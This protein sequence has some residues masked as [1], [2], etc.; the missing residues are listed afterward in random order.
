MQVP[1]QLAQ[2]L[3]GD[4]AGVGAGAV[5][6]LGGG[7]QLE[8]ADGA[9]GVG[10]AQVG[11]A[12]FDERAVPAAGVLFGRGDRAAPS[13][14][15]GGGAGRRQG[16]ERG[17]AVGLGAVGGQP[18]ED[19]GQVQGLGGQA[20]AGFGAAD[21]PVDGVGAVDRLQDV[22]QPFGQGV[23]VGDAEGHSRLLDPLLGPGEPGGQGGRGEGER[24]GDAGDRQAQDGVEHERGAHGGVDRRV[25]AHQHQFQA[26]VADG[27]HVGCGV[28][29]RGVAVRVQRHPGAHGGR[30][31]V[32]AQ[33]VAG[34]RE[35]PGLG[36]GGHAV[37]RPGR[38]GALVG[39][40]EGVLGGGQVSGGR[41]QQGE[42]A[43]VGG[44]GRAGGPHRG[45]GGQVHAPS[46]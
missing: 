17:Q 44:A 20:G 10:G 31:P 4:R 41:G 3:P 7:L 1:V 9:Q 33:P 5:H 40:G 36:I 29:G 35:Q 32:V 37:A 45:T 11:A 43:P 2:V 16:D 15:P 23:P 28:G 39:V 24:G 34:H 21:L 42:Q 18:R 12:A 14:Q 30:P 27:V 19:L 25:G 38:E 26:A 8:A 6:R 22:V 13:V 46:M